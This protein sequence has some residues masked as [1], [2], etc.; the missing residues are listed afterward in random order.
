MKHFTFTQVPQMLGISR[1]MPYYYESRGLLK[2][3]RVGSVYIVEEK[4]YLRFKEYLRVK[5]EE[6]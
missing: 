3:E 5:R 1:T 6:K 2:A 4:E